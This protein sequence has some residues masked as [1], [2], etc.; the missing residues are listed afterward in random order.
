VAVPVP[1][2]RERVDGMDGVARCDERADQ[3][4]PVQLD[5]DHDL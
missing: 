2:D 3:E 4:S 5:A 1:V